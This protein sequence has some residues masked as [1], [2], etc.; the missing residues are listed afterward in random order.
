MKT[1]W[2]WALSGI[3]V[4]T[5]SSVLAWVWTRC[6]V[7]RQNQ[8][9]VKVLEALRNHEPSLLRAKDLA[10]I[11]GSTPDEVSDSLERLYMKGRVQRSNGTFADPAPLWMRVVR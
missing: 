1:F 11:I 3:S 8:F 10:T 4:T 9:D 6:K 7:R 5:L 2:S